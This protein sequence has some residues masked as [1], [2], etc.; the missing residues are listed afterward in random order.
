MQGSKSFVQS[1]PEYPVVENS[2]SQ[3][4]QDLNSTR[5]L[6]LFRTTF[7]A[8]GR[9]IEIDNCYIAKS[10][11]ISSIKEKIGDNE[12]SILTCEL[13]KLL[14]KGTE[15]N[16]AEMGYIKLFNSYDFLLNVQ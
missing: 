15:D 8:E 16:L 3:S 10:P 4:Q 2:H 9:E 11:Y 14:F 12:V 13:N 5:D 6:S 1:S 7:I